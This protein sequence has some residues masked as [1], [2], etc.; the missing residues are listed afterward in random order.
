MNLCCSQF[1]SRD[2]VALYTYTLLW[3]DET[4]RNHTVLR[5]LA[6]QQVQRNMDLMKNLV[7]NKNK[8]RR[9]VFDVGDCVRINIPRIDRTGVDRRSLPCKVLEV[10]DGACI[11]LGV[12][13]AF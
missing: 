7:D 3:I 5:E 6:V 9:L 13:M 1:K 12:L 11:V 10:L 4:R 8:K 2:C